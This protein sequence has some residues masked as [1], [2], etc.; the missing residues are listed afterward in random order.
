MDLKERLRKATTHGYIYG[1]MPQ[2][3]REMAEE[4]ADTIA[5]LERKL[6]VAREGLEAIAEETDAGRHDGLPE[7]C[8]A[9]EDVAMWTIARTTLERISDE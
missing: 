9:H 1:Y 3:M 2:Q 7:P 8:P 4:A 6:E 5:A